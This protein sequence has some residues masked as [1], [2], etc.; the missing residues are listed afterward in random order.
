MDKVAGERDSFEQQLHRLLDAAL[1]VPLPEREQWIDSLPDEPAGLKSSLRDLLSRSARIAA[2]D[3]LQTLP[4]LPSFE[5]APTGQ[6]GERPGDGVGPYRLIRELGSGGMGA[7]W[8]AERRDGMVNRPVALKLPHGAWKRAGLAERMAREREILATL[9]HPGIAHLYDA[10]LAADGQPYLAIEYIEGQR[11]DDY[12]RDRHL[13]T[14]A[15]L[16]LFV[17]VAEAVA[18]A[19]SKLVVHRDLK[20]ANLLVTPE[21]TVRLLDFG[22]AKLLDE[23][24]TTETKLTEMSGRALTP[25]YASPEQ[26]L[27]APLTIASDVYS[28]G[29]VLYELLT[30]QR[31]YKLARDSRGAL[32]EAILQAEP[33]PPSAI[34]HARGANRAHARALRGDLDTI[35]LKALKKDPLERYPTVHALL[36][37]IE[38]HLGARPVLAQPDSRWYRAS[39]FVTRNKLAVTATA[40]IFIAV[41]AGAS[42]AAWQA[43]VALAEKSRAEEVQEFIS[44]VFREADPT[45]GKGDVLSGA[46]LLLQAENRLRERTDADPQLRLT[47]LAII[48]ESLL[49]LQEDKDSARVIQEALRLQQTLSP[50]DRTVEARLHLLLSQAYELTGRQDDALGE[51]NRS[52]T[53]LKAAGDSSSALFAQVKLQQAALGIVS[54]DYALAES[55]AQ[56][57]IE[58]ATA[59]LGPQSSEVAT[60]LQQLSHLYTLTQRREMAVEPARRAFD[61]F[62]ARHARNLNHTDVIEAGQYYGQALHTVGDFTAASTVYADATARAAV[63]FGENSRLY[64]EMLSAYVPLEIDIGDL[65]NATD[66]ARRAVAIYLRSGEAGSVAHAGRVRKLANAL[67]AARAGDE[68]TARSEEALRLAEQARSEL[69]TLHA[70]GGYALALAYAGRFDE[71]ERELQQALTDAGDRPTRGQHL[72]MRNLGTTLRLRGRPAQALP[73]LEKA[74][75]AAAAQHSHRGDLAH[76]LLEAGLTKLALDDAEGAQSYF[77]RAEALFA[78]VQQQHMTPARAD[79]LVGQARVHIAARNYAA[80]LPLLEKANAFWREFSPENHWAGEAALWLG[81]CYRTMGRKAEATAALN[82]ARTLLAR[83]PFSGNRELN[84]LEPPGDEGSGHGT[85]RATP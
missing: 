11:I 73:W 84:G 29:V 61:I 36:E 27:G 47:L 40:A 30:G 54:A 63:A 83:S 64:G 55:A 42:I 71:S 76:G 58:V 75:T 82:R 1:D 74:T 72:A 43:R 66:H 14:K 57:G 67:I 34:L 17:Q 59:A 37:D 44:S 69:E 6:G 19:H 65:P 41:L 9:A 5:P 81:H 56:Q 28:L 48:G 33:V 16:R 39:R 25:D 52:F 70:R 7:V 60:G 53:S 3:F 85:T 4:R 68:A 13:D 24:Q 20:P 50:V 10:G 79:L 46:E 12:C 35:V 15:R 49:G 62:V 18:Y 21:G 38:R 78:D 26:I 22:I 80:A 77:S 45:Q 51:L 23:G 2:G 31:P 32:E 8:L